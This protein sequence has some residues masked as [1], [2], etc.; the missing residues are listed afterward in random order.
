[1]KIVL[2]KDKNNYFKYLKRGEG[3]KDISL[4]P[5]GYEDMGYCDDNTPP[6]FPWPPDGDGKWKK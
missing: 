2:K 3:R 6:P 1:M 4:K 5:S